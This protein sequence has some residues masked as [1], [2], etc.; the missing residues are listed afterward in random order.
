MLRAVVDALSRVAEDLVDVPL[1]SLVR[2]NQL[3]TCIATS[4]TKKI[5]Y[6]YQIRCKEKEL[7]DNIPLM[8]NFS[9]IS[10]NIVEDKTTGH[11]AT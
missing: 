7:V 2:L 4:D 8:V 6:R 9:Y 10:Q 1:L 3:V 5:K 11:C